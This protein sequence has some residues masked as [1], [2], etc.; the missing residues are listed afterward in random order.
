[1]ITTMNVTALMIA[2]LLVFGIGAV[3]AVVIAVRKEN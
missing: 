3:A 2:S 1:M